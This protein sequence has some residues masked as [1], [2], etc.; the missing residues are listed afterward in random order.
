M[1]V[2]YPFLFVK[3]KPRYTFLYIRKIVVALSLILS[4]NYPAYCI[5]VLSVTNITAILLINSYKME[6]WRMETRFN[7]F[8]E[9]LQLVLM[10]GMAIFIMIGEGNQTNFKAN[11]SYFLVIIS[12]GILIYYILFSLFLFSLWMVKKFIG[13]D[14]IA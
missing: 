3:D 11:F 4:V 2:A 13:K 5:G 14:F 7:A 9:G 6:K 10:I 12:V 8:G 1:V